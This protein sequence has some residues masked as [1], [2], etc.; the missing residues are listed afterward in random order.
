MSAARAYL[1][2]VLSRPNLRVVTWAHV[3][4]ILFDGT[5]ATGVE[6]VLRGDVGVASSTPGRGGPTAGR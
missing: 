6:F 3:T 4:R 2:P 5:R 1:H